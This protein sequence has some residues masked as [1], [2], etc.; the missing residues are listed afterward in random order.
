M[1]RRMTGRLIERRLRASSLGV[2]GRD[3]GDALRRVFG[4]REEIEEMFT[5]WEILLTKT[6]HDAC[7]RAMSSKLSESH[8]PH[9]EQLSPFKR[10]KDQGTVTAKWGAGQG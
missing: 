6:I 1:A 3:L 7:E 9:Y 8:G 5:E 2:N 4:S 10:G